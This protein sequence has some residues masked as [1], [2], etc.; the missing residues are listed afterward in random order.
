MYIYLLII[1]QQSKTATT[2]VSQNSKTKNFN[3]LAFNNPFQTV[4][5]NVFG[6]QDA[7]SPPNVING[8]HNFVSFHHGTGMM[9]THCP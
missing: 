9:T 1:F 3:K 7:E 2:D 8:H 5:L 6:S 4:F